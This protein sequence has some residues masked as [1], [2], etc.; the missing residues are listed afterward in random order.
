MALFFEWDTKPRC[1]VCAK[2]RTR[3]SGV[4]L[5]DKR[6][7]APN[8]AMTQGGEALVGG[9]S[10][11]LFCEFADEFGHNSFHALLVRQAE[12]VAVGEL[13]LD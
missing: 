6:G 3:M 1:Y 5:R 4:E 10:L 12:D 13:L 9:Q 8:P 7:H 2:H 11:L